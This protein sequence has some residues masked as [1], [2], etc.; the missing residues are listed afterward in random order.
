MYGSIVNFTFTDKYDN[1]AGMYES[2]A[3]AAN[4][5]W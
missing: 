4:P 2:F 1:M 3:F 5:E